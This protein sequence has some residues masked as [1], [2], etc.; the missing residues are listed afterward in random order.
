[1]QDSELLRT[2]VPLPA[3]HNATWLTVQESLLN[4]SSRTKITGLAY[5]LAEL[6]GEIW[7]SI[8]LQKE[9]IST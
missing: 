4:P 6:R 7:T 1:M 9:V 8:D 5:K 2:Q 3:I